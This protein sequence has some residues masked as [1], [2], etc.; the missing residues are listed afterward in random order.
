TTQHRCLGRLSAAS[1]SAAQGAP[2]D[3]GA[4]GRAGSAPGIPAHLSQAAL[5]QCLTARAS[6]YRPGL[7]PPTCNHVVISNQSFTPLLSKPLSSTD[8][9]SRE[10][11]THPDERGRA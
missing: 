7:E 10:D 6:D 4:E 2:A 3:P 5:K 1:L 8:R 11:P 9:T